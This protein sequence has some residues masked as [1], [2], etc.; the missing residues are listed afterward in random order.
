MRVMLHL[1]VTVRNATHLNFPT[2]RPSD[3]PYFERDEVLA[4]EFHAG[5]LEGHLPDSH[6]AAPRKTA[7]VS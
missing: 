4:P 2:V 5:L 6:L 3:E 1:Q 7:L